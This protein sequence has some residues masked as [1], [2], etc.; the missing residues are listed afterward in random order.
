MMRDLP[1]LFVRALAA[2]AFSG[3]IS[4]V[5]LAPVVSWAQGTVPEPSGAAAPAPDT[6]TPPRTLPMVSTPEN[7]TRPPAADPMAQGINNY[8]HERLRITPAQEP[9]WATLTQVMR[10]NATA[11][12]PLL[13]EQFQARQRGNSIEMLSAGEQLDTAQLD[14]LRKFIAAYQ[15]IYDSMSDEQKQVAD[16]VFRRS[17]F[18]EEPAAPSSVSPGYPS[19]SSPS[20]YTAIPAYPDYP[21]AY[22]FP[23]YGPLFDVPFIGVVVGPR[24]PFH[25]HPDFHAMP[26]AMHMSGGPGYPGFQHPDFHAL[27]SPMHIS[28]GPG[29]PGFQHPDFHALPSPMH[30]SGVPGHP[31]IQHPDFHALPPPMPVSGPS[32]S[33]APF[34]GGPR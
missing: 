12:A 14:G 4:F 15:A 1:R 25:G 30:V 21:P 29:Y 6:G 3:S 2:A 26:P 8:L 9:L 22:Y 33:A 23:E 7:G 5:G 28:G 13:R 16:F 31:G 18:A 27:P 11:L 34:A 17:Q 20:D 19:V 24:F 10:D 32:R